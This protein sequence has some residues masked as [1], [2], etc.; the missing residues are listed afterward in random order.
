[1]Y[2][3]QQQRLIQGRAS[4]AQLAEAE[5]DN[6]DDDTEVEEIVVA[7]GTGSRAEMGDQEEYIFYNEDEEGNDSSSL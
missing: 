5:K 6:Y 4:H 1:M 2:E 3:K 7:S